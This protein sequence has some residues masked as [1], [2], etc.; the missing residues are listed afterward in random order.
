MIFKNYVLFFFLVLINS[1]ALAQWSTNPTVNNVIANPTGSQTEIN[2]I[3]DGNSGAISVW[4]DF[5]AGST[6][7]IYVQKIDSS[8]VVKWGINGTVLCNE[9]ESQSQAAICADGYGGAIIV[10]VDNR[11]GTNTDIYAQRIDA[12][13]IAQWAT[14]GVAVCT[15]ST[16]QYS[17]KVITDGFGAALIAWSDS[18]N[19]NTDI[20]AQSLDIFNS[21]NPNWTTDGV[22]IC[23]ASGAQTGHKLVSDGNSGAIIAWQDKRQFLNDNIYAQ[24]V[25]FSGSVQWAVNGVVVCNATG[26]QGSVDIAPNGNNGAIIIWEDLRNSQYDIFASEIDFQG[27]E[28]WNT[29]GE[30]ICTNPGNQRYP[31]LIFDI[32]GNYFC[33]WQ[34]DAAGDNDIYAQKVDMSGNLVWNSSGIAVVA[35]VDFQVSPSIVPDNLGGVI[36]SW[37]DYR[38]GSGYGDIYAQKLD[39]AGN[40]GW[41]P[42][43]VAVATATD[44]QGPF[45]LVSNNSY[46]AILVWTDNRLQTE[47]DIYA[48]RIYKEGYLCVPI[49]VHLG[50]DIEQCA[51]PVLTLDAGN[52]GAVYAWSTGESTQTISLSTSGSYNVLVTAPGGC[53]N[54]DTVNVV[55]NDL[56]VVN[57]G[58]DITQCGGNVALDAGNTGA[59]YLWSNLVTTQTIQVS[60][61]GT[62]IVEVTDGNAC[63]NKDTID[64]VIHNVPMVNLGADVTQCSGTVALDAQNTGLTFLW[65]TGSANQTITVSATGTYSVMVTDGNGCF[66]SDTVSVIINTL[67]NVIYIETNDTVCT[68]NG[69]FN[70]TSANPGGGTYS[71][72]AVIGNVFDP[73][74]SG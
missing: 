73:L 24:R 6:S 65:S 39:D 48:Q 55:I 13:G 22:D 20:Y 25:D 58:A 36:I 50:T 68:Q 40:P 32:S 51:G 54:R 41:Q 38:N 72:T 49:S 4:T 19:G 28:Q 14:N 16:N 43:G 57:L 44:E 35:E 34:D 10:W 63:T 31:K 42:D 37:Q 52:V 69:S 47:T 74:M 33:T 30:S 12:N 3:A 15:N 23:S 46:G 11:S 71:G 27:I 45:V 8:G 60:T 66:N 67:P 5:R 7:D 2:A 1:V 56:P 61:G 64:V 62:Y 70:L 18:R 29:N 21:G 9:V 53:Y 26:N 59:S 17:P